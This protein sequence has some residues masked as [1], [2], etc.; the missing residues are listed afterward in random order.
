MMVGNTP[1]VVKA[2]TQTSVER[3]TY[4]SEFVGCSHVIEAVLGV[5]DMVRCLSYRVTK[6]SCIFCNN[7]GVVLAACGMNMLIKKRSTAL[8]FHRTRETIACGAIEIQHIDG[9]SNWSDFLTKAVDNVKFMACTRALM[10]PCDKAKN[11]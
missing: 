2:L 3:S 8:A 5:R 9:A 11:L 7:K 1:V 6:P 10:F 4:G